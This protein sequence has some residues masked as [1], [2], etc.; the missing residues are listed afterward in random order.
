MAIGFDVVLGEHSVGG[1]IL[2]QRRRC[3]AERGVGDGGVKELKIA[4][5]RKDLQLTILCGRQLGC[6]NLLEL[7]RSVGWSCGNT[8]TWIPRA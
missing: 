6:T 5:E 2:A 7:R 1:S 3:K 4:P 8:C